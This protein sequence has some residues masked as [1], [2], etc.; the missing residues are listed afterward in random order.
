MPEELRHARWLL[1]ER[2]EYLAQARRDAEDIVEAGRVQAERMVERTEVVARGAARR[3]SRSSP[4]P[5]PTAGACATRPRTT[6][7]R[8]SRAFEVVLERT[9][10][11][12]QQGPRAAPG[13]R[14]AAA[15]R[16]G[17]RARRPRVEVRERRG[18][19]STRT[20]C[21]SGSNRSP[22]PS[23]EWAGCY[24]RVRLPGS[25]GHRGPPL[26]AACLR[27]PA[28][29]HRLERSMSA[30]RIDVADLLTHPGARRP[31]APRGGVDGPRR[32]R[33]PA[34]TSPSASTSCSSGCPTASSSGASVHAR[35]DGRVQH[36]P[37]GARRRPRRRRRPSCSRRHPLDGETYPIEGHEIDLEQ[38]VR[39]AL[40]LELPARAGLRRRALRAGAPPAG[41]P[42]GAHDAEPDDGPRPIP[43]GPRSPSSSSDDP[44]PTE[45][46]GTR[47]T[48]WPSRSARPRGRKTRQRRAVQLAS[49]RARPLDVPE[50]RRGQAAAHR[51][52]QLRLVRRP[53]GDRRRVR[54]TT[55]AMSVTIAVDAMG[56]DHAPGEIVAGAIAGGRGARRARPP[57]RA[58]GRDRAAAARR[59]SDRRRARAR[60]RG[61]RRCTT[62]PRRCARRRTRRSCVCAEA[63][64]RRQ[65]RRDGRA[66]GNTGA[67]MAAALLRMGR[68][69]GVARPAIAVPIPVPGRAAADPRRRRR[70]RRLHRRSGCV[71]FAVMGREYARVA[72]RAST[73]RA[74]ACCRTARRPA[75]ATTCASAVYPL[76][77][78]M[79]GFVGNVE[80]RDFMHRHR[81]RDRHRRLHRQRRAEDDRGRDP[82]H[83]RASCSTCSSSPE[84]QD[85]AEVVMP[86]L[87]EAAE[88]LDPDY[89]GGVRAAR[90]R[91][92][93]RDLARVVERAGDRRTRSRRARRVRRGRRRRA[94]EG[95]GGRMPAETHVER[96]PIGPDEV[97]ADDP[98]AAR[99][100]PRD[101]RGRA[102][103][104]TPSFADDLDADSLALIELVEALEE[105]LGE[106]TVGFSI[107]DEDLG[108][109]HTV[110][111]AVDYVVA[112]ARA[113]GRADRGRCAAVRGAVDP[114]LDARL[115]LALGWTFARPRAARPRAD[116]PLVL[117]RARHRGVERAARVPRR[118][119]ARLRRHR[120]RVPRVPAA[121]RGRAGEAAR[122]RW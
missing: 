41:V 122:R 15:G 88:Q 86:H 91:R 23:G 116:A 120:L 36:L 60:H 14:R 106:R 90:R 79:P 4:T 69:R 30:L 96:S 55:R 85:A 100:D 111:D 101:R 1:K 74:S 83:R 13:R 98:R 28:R 21:K 34:S 65:G 11:T 77:E 50:L 89:I 27:T 35:W 114:E 24:P 102:S 104:S 107:D 16:P 70:D 5:R 76:L 103:R 10:Q 93:V 73:N 8:S 12:V 115:Q 49:R 72:P 33:S 22:S 82:G 61:R 53:P 84:V 68:I 121:A 31:R 45:P 43:A 9:M 63:R 105:E 94:D 95:G 17:R 117:R 6:S 29:L 109:L 38:L 40:L 81:R 67:T 2:E 44:L 20:T 56:G 110:R 75:R 51:V 39:D 26:T 47:S 87:L 113:R 59:R 78:S 71:Q 112:P 97:L 99:R 64:A 18:P 80:G 7:T 52:R 32:A 58:R 108:D 92:R 57:R 19:C 3:R 54:P 48:R 62:R 37:A 25:C 118:L 42:I 66:P 46:V 119:R